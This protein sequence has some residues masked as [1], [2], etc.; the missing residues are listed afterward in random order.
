MYSYALNSPVRF[1]VASGFSAAEGFQQVSQQ[2]TSDA[3]N[4]PQ[5]ETRL[6]DLFDY[7]R[8][9]LIAEAVDEIAFAGLISMKLAPATVGK[10]T[11]AA[12]VLTG[13][14][15][16][17]NDELNRLGLGWSDVWE[18]WRNIDENLRYAQENPDIGLD[19][20]TTGVTSTTA[21]VSNVALD[22]VI[23][24]GASQLIGVPN[25][26]VQSF[27]GDAVTMGLGVEVSGEQ[28]R[29]FSNWWVGL[30]Q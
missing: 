19:A 5:V 28:V 16:Q 7:A 10:G 27:A 26:F 14:F 9:K 29:Q 2:A 18:G 23:N 12:G 20:L 24:A 11:V 17:T 8:R 22:M 13:L 25:A 1:V 3:L 4:G 6:D 15:F 21:I 30:F